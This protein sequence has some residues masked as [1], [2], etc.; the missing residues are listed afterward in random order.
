VV[1]TAPVKKLSAPG[2][3]AIG[4]VVFTIYGFPGL[5]TIDSFDQLAEARKNYYTDGSGGGST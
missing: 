1:P 3:L 4:L 2:L 5:M